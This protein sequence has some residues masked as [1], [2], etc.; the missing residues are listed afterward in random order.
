MLQKQGLVRILAVIVGLTAW[1]QASAMPCASYAGVGEMFHDGDTVCFVWDPSDIDTVYG[2]LSGSGDVVSVSPLDFRAETSGIGGSDTVSGFGFIQVIAKPGFVLDSITIGE[3]G[4][5][6]LNGAS[7]SVSISAEMEVYDWF[8]ASGPSESKFL[9]V[10]GPL[11]IQDANS[12]NWSAEGTVDMSTTTWDG[13]DHVGLS[14]ENILQANSNG[15]G[16]TA[17]IQKKAIGSIALTIETTVIPLP[18]AA[19]L[20][21]SGLGVVGACARR[22]QQRR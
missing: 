14:L 8:N 4:D 20:F 15:A 22:R 21:I 5:Y 18:A 16:H 3:L 7:T 12:Q 11:N 10:T 9:T 6:R 1:T 19:W 17:W 13:V 2:S